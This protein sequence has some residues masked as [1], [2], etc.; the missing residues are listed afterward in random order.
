[1]SAIKSANKSAKASGADMVKQEDVVVAVL[2]ADSFSVR[3]APLTESKPKVF[4]FI[5][6]ISRAFFF[7]IFASCQNVLFKIDFFSYVNKRFL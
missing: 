7:D 2:I 1:M 3:F 5:I 6:N 4:V